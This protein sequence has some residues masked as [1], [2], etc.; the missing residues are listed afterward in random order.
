MSSIQLNQVYVLFGI[1]ISCLLQLRLLLIFSIISRFTHAR[2]HLLPA[3]SVCVIGFNKFPACAEIAFRNLSAD[4]A[5]AEWKVF[6]E[7]RPRYRFAIFNKQII[8][9]ELPSSFSLHLN[10]NSYE[11]LESREPFT[12]I[13]YA[14]VFTETTSISKKFSSHYVDFMSFA[15]TAWNKFEPEE[16]LLHF[17]GRWNFYRSIKSVQ[18]RQKLFLSDQTTKSSKLFHVVIGQTSIIASFLSISRLQICKK[19]DNV[20]LNEVLRMEGEHRR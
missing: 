2:C 1:T 20:Q 6:A 10:D 11:R 14:I 12:R 9:C 7:M 5:I 19:R 3:W 18:W 4:F 13:Y 15:L 16:N 17:G 8:N